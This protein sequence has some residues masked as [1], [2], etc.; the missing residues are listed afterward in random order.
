[1]ETYEHDKEPSGYIKGGEFLHQLSYEG[2]YESNASNFFLGK[3]NGNC[4]EIYLEDPYIFLQI[5]RLFYHKVSIIF[6][7]LL[8]T[9]SKTLCN[10][11]VKFPASTSEHIT[12]TLLQ[13]VVICKMASKLCFLYRAKESRVPDL[14]C[15][16]D[17]R[18]STSFFVIASRLRKL[19][20]GWALSWRRRTSVMFRLGRTV[21][22][23]CRSSFKVPLCRWWCALKSRQEISEHC[24][25]ASYST[26]A[27]VCWKWWRL[28]EKIAS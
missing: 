7:T 21:R 23:R 6:N 11:D 1:M 18:N 3:C 5:M 16:Q 25:I 27:K 28:C 20:W 12:K 24:Y 4:K 8:P 9:L 19:E 26:L 15:E 14:G 22:V 17:G 13:F 10:S 2:R